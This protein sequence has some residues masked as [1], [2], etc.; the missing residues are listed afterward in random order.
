MWALGRAALASGAAALAGIGVL[1]AAAGGGG[2]AQGVGVAA[3]A[4]SLLVPLTLPADVL[5]ARGL[6]T[7]HGPR[8]AAAGVAGAGL[9]GRARNAALV[10]ADVAV[11]ALGVFCALDAAGPIAHRSRAA[12]L[13]AG[14]PTLIV[15]LAQIAQGGLVAEKPRTAPRLAARQ[16]Y[17]QARTLLTQLRGSQRVLA[18]A[19]LKEPPRLCQLQTRPHDER[20]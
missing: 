4:R 19:R 7:L 6:E 10:T 11:A 8:T 12:A 18:G 13:Q 14:W 20:R 17:G 2:A 16:T 5:V 15:T 9:L 1:D 3:L